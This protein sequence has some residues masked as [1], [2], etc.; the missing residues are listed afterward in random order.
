[1]IV[2]SEQNRNDL[3][4][5]PAECLGGDSDLWLLKRWWCGDLD[6][7][8]ECRP[9]G[10]LETLSLMGDL[11]GDLLPLIS[12]SLCCSL[13]FSSAWFLT[14]NISCCSFNFCCLASSS[15]RCIA[16]TRTCSNRLCSCNCCC[17][18]IS[19]AR[20]FWASNLSTARRLSSSPRFFTSTKSS[21]DHC[22]LL[23][24]PP[25]SPGGFLSSFDHCLLLPRLRPGGDGGRGREEGLGW[26]P[27][28]PERPERS[29]LEAG[30]GRFSLALGLAA[31]RAHS[32]SSDESPLPSASG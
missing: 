15:C 23:P 12:L 14:M 1:M 27:G 26:L 6:L 25:L 13:A 7:D 20:R 10:D 4:T 30:G 2:K 3:V 24:P 19:A 29:G 21:T 32:S 11:L 22:G 18:A 9:P 8:L 17:L 16:W 31:W 28:R 5:K